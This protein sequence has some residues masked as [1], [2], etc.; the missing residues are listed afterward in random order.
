MALL[1]DPT[2]ALLDEPPSVIALRPTCFQSGFVDVMAVI[3]KR[4]PVIHAPEQRAVT[5]VGDDVI[6]QGGNQGTAVAQVDAP[7][8][9]REEQPRLFAP[10]VIVAALGCCWPTR[11]WRHC[12]TPTVA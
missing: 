12:A 6:D 3:A 1:D 5:L 11:L 10:A 9:A 2:V 8:I 4:L 7:R